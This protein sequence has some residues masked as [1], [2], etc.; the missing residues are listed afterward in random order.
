MGI[1]AFLAVAF[2]VGALDNTFG[3]KPDAAEAAAGFA[4]SLFLFD[5]WRSLRRHAE[6]DAAFLAWLVENRDAVASGAAE[7]GGLPIA[8]QTEL[9]RYRVV[10]CLLVHREV[11]SRHYVSEYESGL[12]AALR[13]TL[14]SL[15]TGWWSHLGP[16]L[17]IAAIGSNLRG[18]RR[19]RVGDLL[20]ELTGHQRQVVHLTERAAALA[21]RAMAERGYPEG[22]ALQVEV[23]GDPACPEYAVRY[24]D[25][26]PVDGSAWRSQAHGLTVLVNKRDAPRVEGLVVD[27]EGDGYVFKAPAP[28]G[29]LAEL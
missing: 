21:R 7:Y 3:V 9:R 28:K 10:C 19:C 11:F 18:G 12:A 17:T 1:I 26:P 6:H 22:S 13:L 14:C 2:L 29:F 23:S 25:C 15:V 16:F 5:T 24:D 27:S 8:P 4:I 20:D